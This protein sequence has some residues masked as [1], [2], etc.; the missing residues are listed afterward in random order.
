MGR[1]SAKTNMQVLRGHHGYQ[2]YLEAAYRRDTTEAHEDGYSYGMPRQFSVGSRARRDKENLSRSRCSTNAICMLGV[3]QRRRTRQGLHQKDARD[4]TDY[5][6]KSCQ[7]NYWSL[8]GDIKTSSQ[9]QNLPPPCRTTNLETQHRDNRKSSLESKHPRTGEVQGQH[10]K[11]TEIHKPATK[12][13]PR[14]TKMERTNRVNPRDNTSIH[15]TPWWKGPTTHIREDA[16]K[17]E[18]DHQ[19]ELESGRNTL[20]IYTDGS[21]I[22]GHTGAAAV[23]PRIRQTRK[24]YM[25]RDTVSTVYAGELQGINMALQ[26]A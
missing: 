6:S 1:D 13:Q 23:C 3:V 5:P 12:N 22:D 25:G 20:L 26:L 19:R 10:T 24:A 4:A 2:A 8:Q 9:H 7:N 17:A 18:S 15:H 11:Q 21:G 16:E 14:S